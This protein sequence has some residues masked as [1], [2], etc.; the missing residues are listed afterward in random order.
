MEIY[1]NS[2]IEFIL[3]GTPKGHRHLRLVVKVKG[4]YIV[5][6]EATVAAIVRAYTVIKTHPTKTAIKLVGSHLMERKKGYAEF[7]LLEIDADEAAL[8]EELDNI[9]GIK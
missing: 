8:V 5:F 7:Q 6:H 3:L 4:R 9:L 2:D 1:R